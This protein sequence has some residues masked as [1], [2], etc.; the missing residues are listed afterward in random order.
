LG[1]FIIFEEKAS[2]QGIPHEDGDR[3]LQITAELDQTK[4]NARDYTKVLREKFEPMVAKYPD[5]RVKFGGT[6]QFTNEVLSGFFWAMIIAMLVI[7][8]I[9]VVLFNSFSEPLIVM[10]AIPFGLVGVIF[11]FLIHGETMSF[12]ALIGILGLAGVVVNNSLVMLKFLNDKEED[13]CQKNEV[14][15][16][17]HVADAATQRFR[18]IT[19]TT[20]TTVAGLLP[21]LYGLFGGRVDFLFPRLLSLSWGLV[22][23]TFITL[24]LIP[25]FYLVE[26]NV[27]IWASKKFGKFKRCGG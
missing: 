18:P 7:Y 8:L 13:I 20:V 4:V 22:F 14:L 12:L 25:C 27:S 1:S 2:V 16:L 26:R 24:F 10:L 5:F 23:S 3:S 6:E 19:L 11:A 9:L 17:Q 15:T 21:S